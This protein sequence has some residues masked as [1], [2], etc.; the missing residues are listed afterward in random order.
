MEKFPRGTWVWTELDLG[1]TCIL[2]KLNKLFRLIVVKQWI[3]IHVL[4]IKLS[5]EETMLR[6][7]TAVSNKLVASELDPYSLASKFKTTNW[8]QKL[9][10]ENKKKQD[11]Y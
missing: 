4:E 9:I 5:L 3:L 7:T 11:D 2:I 1:T 8:L 10:K 6:T